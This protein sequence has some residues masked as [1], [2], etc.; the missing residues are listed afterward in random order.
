MTTGELEADR[1]RATT[2]CSD[3]KSG[4]AAGEPSSELFQ[5]FK[6]KNQKKK[7]IPLLS[8]RNVFGVQLSQKHTVTFH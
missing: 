3:F 4:A 5:S 1:V 6:C 2:N 8:D 7:E